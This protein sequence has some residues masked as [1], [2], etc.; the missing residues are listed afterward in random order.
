M[1][2]F[3]LFACVKKKTQLISCYKSDRSYRHKRVDN[4]KYILGV[5]FSSSYS[6]TVAKKTHTQYTGNGHT[7]NLKTKRCWC[8]IFVVLRKR[9]EKKRK[10]TK[11]KKEV[12]RRFVSSVHH[13]RGPH[14]LFVILF[15]RRVGNV[16]IASASS[17]AEGTSRR[18]SREPF[19]DGKIQANYDLFMPVFFRSWLLLL[20]ERP[21][22]LRSHTS[23]KIKEK[24]LPY[25]I[26]L[27]V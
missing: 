7:H 12:L 15:Y 10:K 20:V 18:V 5:F 4:S 23:H 6:Q 8:W 2:I 17:V 14:H 25:V 24:G 22:R 16:V 27:R 1:I 13:Q 9:K 21:F 11:T 19:N 3:S 26:S